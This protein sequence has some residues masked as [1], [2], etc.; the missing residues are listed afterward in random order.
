M[1][2]GNLT[3]EE[4]LAESASLIGSDVQHDT[5]SLTFLESVGAQLETDRQS[6]SGVDPNEE[7]VK[8]L[9]YQRGFQAAA[10]VI[11]SVNDTLDELFTLV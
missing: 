4:Y 2:Q 11:S 10:R 1:E 8:M 3:L 5:S 9:Q 6:V 7:M